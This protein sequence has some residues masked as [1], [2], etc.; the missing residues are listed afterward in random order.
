M[1]SRV[2]DVSVVGDLCTVAKTQAPKRPLIIACMTISQ[3]IPRRRY[4]TSQRSL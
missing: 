4:R 3:P 2:C 1:T